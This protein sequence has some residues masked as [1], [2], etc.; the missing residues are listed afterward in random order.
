MQKDLGTANPVRQH[1]ARNPFETEFLDEIVRRFNRPNNNSYFSY[2]E[3]H[4]HYIVRFGERLGIM[5]VTWYKPP[6]MKPPLLN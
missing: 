2:N 5:N 1:L 3:C 4:C 6:F